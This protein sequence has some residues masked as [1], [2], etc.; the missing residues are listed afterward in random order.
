[1]FKSHQSCS[2][3]A[4]GAA[5][6]LSPWRLRWPVEREGSLV[7]RLQCDDADRTILLAPQAAGSVEL[8]ILGHGVGVGCIAFTPS[9]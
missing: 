7:D 5:S 1:M 9:T 6:A 3:R 8:G 4:I 2:S